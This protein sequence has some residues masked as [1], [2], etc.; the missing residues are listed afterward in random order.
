M[1]RRSEFEDALVER[2]QTMRAIVP[3]MASEVALARRESARLRRENASL[4]EQLSVASDGA[5]QMLVA[6]GAARD[7][8]QAVSS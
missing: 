4:R 8:V 7:S 1:T 3:A 6:G 2:L 5:S